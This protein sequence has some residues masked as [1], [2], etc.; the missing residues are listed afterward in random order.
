[1][2]G[3]FHNGLLVLALLAACSGC[4]T[5]PDGPVGSFPEYKRPVMTWVP[6]YAVA[7]GKARLIES[8]AGAGMR[9]ALTHLGLQFW[10]PTGDGGLV[11]AGKKND[12]SD[13]A[14]RDLRDWGH[15]NG[16]RVLLCVYNDVGRWDWDLARAAFAEHPDRFLDALVTEMN[17][18]QLDGIDVDL[19]GN[20]TFEAD[21]V[22][23]RSFIQKLSGRLHAQGKHLTVDSFAY[24]WNAPNQKWWPEI[25]PLVD[26]M[27]TMG[28]EETG[29]YA[30]GWRGY[31]AQKSAADRHAAKLMIGLPSARN[32][33]SGNNLTEHLEWLRADGETGVSFWDAQ[34]S[35]ADWRKPEVWKALREISGKQ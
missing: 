32:A 1:M 4:R 20:G 27:T 5:N 7:K 3:I 15:A 21:R 11:R 30:P 18:L 23:Y 26:G 24:E 19:E 12:T 25:F 22:A 10:V 28:Y 13:A 35:A 2:S 9:D 31:A 29:A 14:I 33:W 16:V 6:P 8:Y 34:I 17:R